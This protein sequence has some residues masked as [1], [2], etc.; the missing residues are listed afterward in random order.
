MT[1]I[2]SHVPSEPEF[3]EP[4]QDPDGTLAAVDGIQVISDVET[5]GTNEQHLAEKGAE[6]PKPAQ[7]HVPRARPV[8]CE[9]TW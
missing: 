3:G 7:K 8:L 1:S 6:H 4:L 9:G 2:V 5:T